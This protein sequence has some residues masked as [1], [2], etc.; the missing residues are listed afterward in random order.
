MI[1]TERGKSIY[2]TQRGVL[3][4]I[5]TRK[6]H[7]YADDSFRLYTPT[8]PKNENYRLRSSAYPVGEFTMM[9][10]TFKNGPEEERIVYPPEPGEHVTLREYSPD[11]SVGEEVGEYYVEEVVSEKRRV[12]GQVVLVKINDW[13]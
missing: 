4:A 9:D 8:D 5:T 7:A 1:R 6:K 3:K 2:P 12:S 13:D 11:G 10:F